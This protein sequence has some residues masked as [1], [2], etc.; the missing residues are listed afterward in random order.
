M[1]ELR[2]VLL[3]PVFSGG[4]SSGTVQPQRASRALCATFAMSM[5]A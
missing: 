2:G 1:E 4:G 5:L 3:L